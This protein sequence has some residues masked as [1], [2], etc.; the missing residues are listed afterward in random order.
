MATQV[1][2]G[3]QKGFD[4]VKQLLEGVVVVATKTMLSGMPE[5][6]EEQVS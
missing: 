2:K 6:N 4:S 3:Y 5:T 1:A